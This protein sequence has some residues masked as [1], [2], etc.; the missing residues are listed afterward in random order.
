MLAIDTSAK[1]QFLI[2]AMIGIFEDS[3]RGCQD[4]ANHKRL[5]DE[6][7]EFFRLPRG[8]LPNFLLKRLEI[9]TPEKLAAR[10]L[11]NITAMGACYG[12]ENIERC[13]EDIWEGKA[14]DLDGAVRHLRGALGC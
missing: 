1:G 3:I 6:Y 5:Q 14:G 8:P 13:V 11:E 4:P 2:E 10:A 12:F 9:Q 7:R